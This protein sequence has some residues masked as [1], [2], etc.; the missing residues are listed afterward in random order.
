VRPDYRVWRLR[1]GGLLLLLVLVPWVVLQSR[2]ARGGAYQVFFVV[3]LLV[4]TGLRVRADSL[5]LLVDDRG[6]LLG[7]VGRSRSGVRVPWTSVRRVVLPPGTGR[8]GVLLVPDAPRPPGL[9]GI[10]RDPRHPDV[11]DPL[12]VREVPGLDGAALTRAVLARG[13]AVAAS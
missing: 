6:V 7:A 4:L 12:L 8:V 2:L 9:R 10:I 5:R 13:V 3:V 1:P 11:L